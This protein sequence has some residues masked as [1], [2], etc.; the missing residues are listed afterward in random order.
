[1]AKVKSRNRKSD[2]KLLDLVEV[3]QQTKSFFE[4]NQQKIGIIGGGL[5]LAVL[6]AIAYIFLYQKPRQERAIEQMMVAQQQFEKDSFRLA[7][8]NPGGGYSGFLDIIDTYSGTKTANLAK[9]YSGICYLHLGQ[10]DAAIDYLNAYS[11]ADEATKITRLGTLGDAYSEKKDFDKA[12]SSYKNAIDA[13]NNELLTAY[14]IKKLGF[15]YMHQNDNAN[16][17]VQFN[18]L[19]KDFPLSP[20]ATDVD[21][22][23]AKLGGE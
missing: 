7:L 5:L 23:I 3:K 6:G 22:Y 17:L 15:L 1:M 13:G 14:Y 8:T 21:K 12:I 4:H 20:E 9:Y 2:E 16:A 19:K 10:F 11:P 18:K